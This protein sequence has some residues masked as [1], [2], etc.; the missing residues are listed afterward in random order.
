MSLRLGDVA[1]DFTA[2]IIEGLI[3]FHRWLGNS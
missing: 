2:N 1:P 3:E